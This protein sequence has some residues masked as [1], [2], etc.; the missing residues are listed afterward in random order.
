MTTCVVEN[1]FKNRAARILP[2]GSARHFLFRLFVAY[3]SGFFLKEPQKP[4][5]PDL[6]FA[7]NRLRYAF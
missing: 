7:V 1:R 2:N 5:G 3:S 6:R 4:Q